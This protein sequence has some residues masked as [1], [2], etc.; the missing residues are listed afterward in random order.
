MVAVYL[1]LK[2]EYDFDFLSIYIEYNE[3]LCQWVL[4]YL[5]SRIKK[6]MTLYFCR[7][8]RNLLILK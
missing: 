8:L 6:Y 7:Y 3:I 2:R 4:T 1:L 5:G